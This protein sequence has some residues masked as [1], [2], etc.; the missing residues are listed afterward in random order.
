L[1]EDESGS[2]ISNLS[3][4]RDSQE[5]DDPCHTLSKGSL[6]HRVTSL[7]SADVIGRGACRLQTIG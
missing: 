3:I 6:I 7:A 4:L 5:G 2:A 1:A